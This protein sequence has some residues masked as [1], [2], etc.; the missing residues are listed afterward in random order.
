MVLYKM[1]RTNIAIARRLVRFINRIL[2]RVVLEIGFGVF[3]IWTKLD[4]LRT[5]FF[6]EMCISK[7]YFSK[8]EYLWS[9]KEENLSWSH[10][11]N[12]PT[13]FRPLADMLIESKVLAPTLDYEIFSSLPEWEMEELL[14]FM[15]SRTWFWPCSR[16]KISYGL[17]FFH[18]WH[19]SGEK[20]LNSSL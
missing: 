4:V 11:T 1:P 20:T 6:G 8:S 12:P 16:E 19:H 10:E 13:D 7:D 9:M 14:Q 17:Y 18:F 3:S 5:R 15:S 2:N